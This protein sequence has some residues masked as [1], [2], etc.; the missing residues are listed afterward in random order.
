MVCVNQVLTDRLP[1]ADY[2]V[3]ETDVQTFSSSHSA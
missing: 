1:S 2:G 3:T